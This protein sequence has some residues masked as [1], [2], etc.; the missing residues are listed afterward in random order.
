MVD[1]R[2]SSIDRLFA[3]LSSLKLAIALI[4]L[5]AAT[6]TIGTLVV[7]A[8][9]AEPGQIERTYAPA[10]IK[11]FA[12]LGFFD[13]YHSWWF[14]ALLTLLGLNLI[15]C[16]ID[17][18]PGARRYFTHPKRDATEAYLQA[19]P[20]KERIELD[21]AGPEAESTLVSVLRRHGL[22]P[23][24]SE[25]RDRRVY[26]AEK[27]RWW[28]LSVFIIH[29][30]LLVIF[31]GGI[32]GARLG[33]E[34]IVRLT[35]GEKTD[36]FMLRE[37]QNLRPIPLGFQLECRSASFVFRD[38]LQNFVPDPLNAQH[39]QEP[40]LV[41]AWYSDLVVYDQ[42]RQ[43][44]ARRIEVN[45]PLVYGGLKFYQASFGIT[46]EVEKITVGYRKK[47]VENTAVGTIDVPAGQTVKVPGTDM[48]LRIA[49]FIPDFVMT[50]QGPASRTRRYW[51]ADYSNPGAL[52]EVIKDDGAR[53]LNWIFLRADLRDI[54]KP[55]EIDYI[56]SLQG[57]EPRY[58]TGLQVA[59]DPGVP[60]VYTGFVMFAI[61]LLLR[62][63]FSHNRYWLL[64][65]PADAG[66]K[67]ILAGHPARN[68]GA[69][70]KGFNKLAEELRRQAAA[71]EAE[72]S[73][74]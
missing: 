40:G 68:R 33:Y 72:I 8:P 48:S 24:L 30:S 22:R 45:K 19:Q 58:Y 57:I 36:R 25:F 46:A 1:N 17:L 11:L 62:F 70:E 59:H 54:H 69:F 27:H 26:F 31:A 7:Q 4:I 49:Q 28:R 64:I 21:V 37:V 23:A 6:A 67:V 15:F 29:S 55:A 61:S 12:L 13:V 2:L 41:K 53:V 16:S 56:L 51:D 9:L 3:F 34:G 63:N 20:F 65:A 32:I 38:D 52:L 44:L 5:L 47:G 50:D 74:V 35:E 39:V 66:V 60:I 73:R 18:W 43:A 71:L 10:T 42:G 14:V